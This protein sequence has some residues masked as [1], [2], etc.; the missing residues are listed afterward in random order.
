MRVT[1][2]RVPV[3]RVNPLDYDK[4]RRKSGRKK[5]SKDSS[6][7]SDSEDEDDKRHKK[8]G[9]KKATKHDKTLELLTKR[10]EELTAQRAKEP[11]RGEKWCVNC[12]MS[13]HST[14]E[15]RQCDFCAARGHLW[16]N[17]NVRLNL[18]MGKGQ[19]VRMV[20]GATETSGPVGG[21]TG[22]RGTGRGSWRG[23]RA[24]RGPRVYT[25]FSCGKEGHFAADCPDKAKPKETPEVNFIGSTVAVN[26]VT[27]SQGPLLIEGVQEI[28]KSSTK[29]KEAV[30]DELAEQR[31]LAAR[32]TEEF[33]KLKP[34]APECSLARQI[35]KIAPKP[36]AVPKKASLPGS[37]KYVPKQDSAG[38]EGTFMKEK[39]PDKLVPEAQRTPDEA[40][41]GPTG[42][43]GYNQRS[44]SQ[45][46]KEG[47]VCGRCDGHT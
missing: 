11:A 43:Q 42:F 26:A 8:K 20:T 25:C 44:G 34:E 47:Q 35:T 31:R 41:Q 1:H 9:S 13:N 45:T 14:E 22:G 40:T 2:Q 24:G 46:C 30:K 27:R 10:I 17:C 19:E 28:P 33:A 36:L 23:G 3:Q 32:L 37:Y 16:E 4:K 29:G 12:R 6:E 18:L 39:V 38:N 21:S 7:S 5:T 15:C